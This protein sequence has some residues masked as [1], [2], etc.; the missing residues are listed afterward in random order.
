MVQAGAARPPGPPTARTADWQRAARLAVALSWLSLVY[1]AIEGGV[2][3]WQGATAGSV[4]L[5]GWGLASFI[6]G[7][8][9]AVIVWRFTG[10]RRLS[11]TAEH[12][13]Q[14]LVAIQFFILAPYVLF[15]SIKTLIEG[16]HPDITVIGMALTATSVVLM[17]LLGR[18]KHRLAE[19]LGS[20]ATAGEGT[21]N[22]LCGVQA[23]AVLAGLAAN[24]AVGAWWLDPL[25]G[26]FIAFVAVKE[27]REAWRGETC[28][29]CA[30]PHIRSA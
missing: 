20:T 23:A 13:A 15:E 7:L 30:A 4:A 1:M 10:S 8:A 29:D 5:V 27:G 19:R 11:E 3:V 26:L 6:E 18:A 16:G 24:A 14:R 17:P 28:C 9:S 12:R 25:I 2:G 22:V 21:Q